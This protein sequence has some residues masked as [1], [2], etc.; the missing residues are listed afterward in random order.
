MERQRDLSAVQVVGVREVRDAKAQV[1]VGGEQRQWFVVDVRGHARLGHALDDGVAERLAL[2]V[3]VHGHEVAG[4]RAFRV[5]VGKREDVHVGQTGLVALDHRA[6]TGEHVGIASELGKPHRGLDVG[7]VAL[8]AGKR[9]VVLPG[10]HFALGERVLRLA[11][12]A[13]KHDLAVE[14]V[15]VEAGVAPGEAAALRRGEILHRMERERAEIGDG[16]AGAALERGAEGVRGVGYDDDAVEAL[17]QGVRGAPA[18]FHA[19]KRGEEAFVVAHA[20][21]EVDGNDGLRALGDE[22]GELVVVHLERSGRRVAQHGGR[23]DV[24]DG[25]AAGRIG[26]GRG[27]HLVSRSDAER[28][29]AAFER[30]GGGVE[31]GEPFGSRELLELPF[32]LLGLRP[33]GDPAAAQRLGDG[34]DL[35]VSH[36]GGRECDVATLHE[37]PLCVSSESVSLTV[38]L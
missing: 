9:D 22:A 33:R 37:N 35:V 10:A 27:D 6:A 5:V 20:P 14:L 36:V 12:Q 11:V 16:A 34:V 17:L 31:A 4:R 18:F 26:V 8:P 23:A 28:A 21:A 7:H 38:Q 25:G 2:A 32:E 24:A 3:Q 1:A 19:F 15:G 13:Q 30:R 29:Q